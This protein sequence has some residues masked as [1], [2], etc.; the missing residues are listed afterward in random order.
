M[1]RRLNDAEL[2]QIVSFFG[3]PAGTALAN[4][5]AQASREFRGN[6]IEE[7]A[8]QG[9]IHTE[10]ARIFRHGRTAAGG[11]DDLRAGL[12]CVIDGGADGAR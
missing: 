5:I 9:A 12:D 10:C 1:G 8:A 3:T 4:G 11:S 2:E 7:L 6:T